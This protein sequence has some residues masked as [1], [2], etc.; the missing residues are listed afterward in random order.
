MNGQVPGNVK[1]IAAGLQYRDFITIGVLL[2]IDNL[3]EQEYINKKIN[4]NQ[5]RHSDIK[6]EMG[7]NNKILITII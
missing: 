2:K 6:R 7:T 1:E 3:L 5:Q 4:R